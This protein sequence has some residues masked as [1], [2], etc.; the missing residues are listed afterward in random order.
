MRQVRILESSQYVAYDRYLFDSMRA[1]R[2]RP[3]HIDGKPTP[4]FSRV[5]FVYHQLN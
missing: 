1:W 5:K 2:Y 3:H 4:V